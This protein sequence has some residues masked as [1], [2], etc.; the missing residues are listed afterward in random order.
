LS[1]LPDNTNFRIAVYV[2]DAAPNWSGGVQ[3]Q[4][5]TPNA[6]PN[7]PL[8]F[9][10]T[11]TTATSLTYHIN[12]GSQLPGDVSKAFVWISQ[13]KSDILNKVVAATDSIPKANLAAPQTKSGLLSG[14]KYY[15][16][17]I[18]RDDSGL[19]S[20]SVILDSTATTISNPVTLVLS[21][22]TDSQWVYV[23]FDSATYVGPSVDRIYIYYRTAG[24]NLDPYAVAD[25]SFTRAELLALPGA[26][27]TLKSLAK[28]TYYFSTTL[29]I[30]SSRSPITNPHDVITVNFTAPPN[31]FHLYLYR[32]DS[33][34]TRLSYY[35][36]EFNSVDTMIG[37]D[38]LI[39]SVVILRGSDSAQML[40]S[41]STNP[42]LRYASLY[43]DTVKQAGYLQRYITGLTEGTKY[44]I[45][46]ATRSRSGAW[47][48]NVNIRRQDTP[49][50]NPLGLDAF[51]TAVKG[52][53]G[54]VVHFMN[55]A[56]INANADSVKLFYRIGAYNTDSSQAP[57]RWYSKAQLLANPY[58]TVRGRQ[59]NTKY[60]FTATCGTHQNT[61]GFGK[62]VGAVNG[63]TVTTGDYAP[64]TQ[65][66]SF[67]PITA[68]GYDSVTFWLTGTCSTKVE[69]VYIYMGASTDSALLATGYRTAA[70]KF[71]V[72]QTG[73]YNGPFT[74][75][76]LSEGSKYFLGVAL[77]S[78]E[79]FWSSPLFMTS[80]TTG[81][82][83]PANNLSITSLSTTGNSPAT[84]KIFVKWSWT[85][86]TRPARI[87]FIYRGYNVP[88]DTPLVN[89]PAG[90]DSVA[91][92]PAADTGTAV[93]NGGSAGLQP[94]TRY[95]ISG[96]VMNTHGI[97]SLTDDWDTLTTNPSS[98]VVPPDTAVYG[99]ADLVATARQINVKNILVKWT[100]SPAAAA[101][102]KAAENGKLHLGYDYNTVGFSIFSSPSFKYPYSDSLR[103][104][105]VLLSGI[106]PKTTYFFG[107]APV[108]T[109]NNHAP[110]MARSLCSLSTVVPA[111]TALQCSLAVT[112]FQS[113]K[114]FWTKATTLAGGNRVFAA[115][116]FV[117]YITIVATDSASPYL[118]A[119][120]PQDTTLS[121]N[122][123]FK[124]KTYMVAVCSTEINLNPFM[125]N[126]G[127]LRISVFAS[128]DFHAFASSPTAIGS[129]SY[130]LDTPHLT[131]LSLLQ[132]NDSLIKVTYTAQDNTET[133]VRVAADLINFPV[134]GDTLTTAV[135]FPAA[136]SRAGSINLA[137]D[138]AVKAGAWPVRTGYIR[139]N[140][141]ELMT[142]L[143]NDPLYF[144]PA[145]SFMRTDTFRLR[146]RFNISDMV[147]DPRIDTT[148]IDSVVIDRKAPSKA[149]VTQTYSRATMTWNFTVQ[150]PD[151]SDLD[152]ILWGPNSAS[153]S[154]SQAYTGSSANLTLVGS[155]SLLV[156]LADRFGN[157]RDYTYKDFTTQKVPLYPAI[158]PVP[159]LLDN[160]N[161]VI[162]VSPK[163]ITNVLEV[164]KS[165][166]LWVGRLR[167]STVDSLLV[168]S[169]RFANLIPMKY[170]FKNEVPG[171]YN[172]G[173]YDAGILL[174][175][176]FDYPVDPGMHFYRLL[177][178]KNGAAFLEYLGGQAGVDSAT[179]KGYVSLS[180]F[181]VTSLTDSF[182]VVIAS[183]NQR[184]R[185]DA[186]A[187]S[188][189][190][191]ADS[192]VTLT[193][194]A[195][196][197]TVNMDALIR[198]FT[199]DSLGNLV[200]LFDSST[201]TLQGASG[202]DTA[203]LCMLSVGGAVKSRM[204]EVSNAGIFCAVTVSDGRRECLYAGDTIRPAAV[205]G[206]FNLV[207]DQW[208]IVALP[209]SATNSSGR[210]ILRQFSNF[211]GVYDRTR[212][213]LYGEPGSNNA[214]HEF[215][216]N[217]NGEFDVTQ[218]RA[219]LLT[220]H[221]TDD[222]N[223]HYTLQNPVLLPP[224]TGRPGYEFIGGGWRL[225]AL[226]FSGKVQLESVIRAS[227]SGRTSGP[228]S[229]PANWANRLWQL[230][231]T[232]QS[233]VFSLIKDYLPGA[234]EGFLTYLYPNDTLVLPVLNDTAFLPPAP[235]SAGKPASLAS[236]GGWR[237]SAVL[238]E[239]ATR[240]VLDNFTSFGV[241]DAGADAFPDLVMPGAQC[242]FGL[243]DGAELKSVLTRANNGKGQVFVLS[244]SGASAQNK[245]LEIGFSG[246]DK[247]PENY[248]VYLN[249]EKTGCSVN[250]RER[251]GQYRF[252]V[253]GGGARLFKVIVGDSGFVKRLID[254]PQPA[255]FAL[256]QNSPNPFNP[257]TVISFSIPEFAPGRIGHT[258]LLL[259][260]YNLRGQQAARLMDAPAQPGVYRRQWAG[261]D[262]NGR[263]LA[264]GI[265]FY[266][267]VVL[268]KDG[269]CRFTATRK[270]L[271]VK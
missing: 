145:D 28:G 138:T 63:D 144:N 25:T 111:V 242:A 259:E 216:T 88:A 123:L 249:D 41:F 94:N 98:D 184:P 6:K 51:E 161:V 125:L 44:Y 141:S 36:I 112:G 253:D 9:V 56:G 266:R 85:S 166:S 171:S 13:F 116:T 119:L 66:L 127:G 261:T 80:F 189:K 24:Y 192:S 122:G 4:A 228:A 205:S 165:A 68:I 105:S 65:T 197:N 95:I 101:A 143:R 22:N 11:N 168:T 180:S 256:S 222:V 183:D 81:W 92:A 190:L 33:V 271:L 75:K 31:F 154:H 136:A 176:T 73:N 224:V 21:Q 29:A 241:V 16:G 132:E 187:S 182:M 258:R 211:S 43:R 7:N 149:V 67:P 255:Q 57:D 220:V 225:I 238:T 133:R 32:P 100:L 12:N 70:Y 231:T 96:W 147:P 20:D 121:L 148:Y 236:G 54:I 221:F 204:A 71:A 76:S 82:I 269:T 201:A 89:N 196:D 174:K 263:A 19:W 39:D 72:P 207:Q 179:G 186:A 14:A 37:V 214:F 251:N 162:L 239:T 2:R 142:A 267:L 230:T 45:G 175:Y 237:L 35:I 164:Q 15:I 26:T 34:M 167:V 246:L 152:N 268:D 173:V 158:P 49:F 1:N 38:T 117:K 178:D 50:R 86:G 202:L 42:A 215:S 30:G 199:Y 91:F 194:K 18:P 209:W 90:F 3:T 129:V 74:I 137:S 170:W 257:A 200:I 130:M 8:V 150:D 60:W 212:L 78:K 260:V 244:L 97:W 213:R 64:P 181:K 264:S 83:P 191:N 106:Q 198:I 118:G 185:F 69:S 140:S 243:T 146:L 229:D 79:K 156:R 240:E 114:V 109:A 107:L 155:D 104:D 99:P 126:Q 55:V 218:G 10:L 227:R 188:L 103:A 250:L 245:D 110:A 134:P 131:G 135:A 17:V 172:A 128:V 62:I 232:G 59:S 61:N 120:P 208:R 124:C 270:M 233:S 235:G 265:Y 153:L 252:Y 40:S 48:R 77:K 93:N 157:F 248:L 163:S 102:A 217:N 223:V 254:A 210:D 108:D 206:A 5:G 47:S 46:V 177:Y 52:D 113:F 53:S 226:P 195:I 87:K 115:D 151:A 234:R 203:A 169:G 84:S 58:D 262:A 247:V 139:L 23:R 159:V 27:M 160:G 193:F 219:F